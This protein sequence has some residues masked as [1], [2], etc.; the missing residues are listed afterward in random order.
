MKRTDAAGFA[1]GNLYTNGNPA[2]AIPATVVDASALNNIQEEIAQTVEFTGATLNGADYT[3]LRT[4]IQSMISSGGGAQINQT[5][6]NN[7]SG[8]ANVVGLTFAGSKGGRFHFDIMRSTSGGN[9]SETGVGFV[10]FNSTT[11]V[12][13]FTY[14]SKFDDAGVDLT[15]TSGGQVQYTSDNMAGSGYACVMRVTGILKFSN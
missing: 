6:N 13:N 4:A 5:I 10:S 9:F 2:L 3:Q 15:I 14:D 11:S 8:A 1:V 12:W 7:Q